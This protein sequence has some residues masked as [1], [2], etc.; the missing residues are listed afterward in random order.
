MT[1]NLATRGM[2][3]SNSRK[4]PP[5]QRVPG[6]GAVAHPALP[7]FERS[8]RVYPRVPT[9]SRVEWCEPGSSTRHVSNTT[10]WSRGGLFIHTQQ[11]CTPGTAL[12]LRL[13]I[14]IGRVELEGVV[15]HK[16]HD[17][18]GVQLDTRFVRVC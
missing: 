16:R 12:T 13:T 5:A 2:S 15:V 8:R 11:T 6:D 4:M 18:M 1:E 14:G 3:I 10:D 9:V 7:P 17:G